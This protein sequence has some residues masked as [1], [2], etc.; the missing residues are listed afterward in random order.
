MN[1]QCYLA[2]SNHYGDR[3]AKRTQVPLMNHINEGLEILRFMGSDFS[4]MEAY[5][6]HPLVQDKTD[7]KVAIDHNTLD[8]YDIKSS[9]ILIAMEYRQVANYYL[10]SDVCDNAKNATPSYFDVVNDMLIADKIQNYKDFM[11]HH[12]ESH[13]N[14]LRL[15][16]YFHQWFQALDLDKQYVDEMVEIIS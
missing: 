15:Y 1:S 7:L 8:Q 2:I 6:L 11:K 12:F 16:T 3:V 13:P 10:S 5:C 9:L 14:Y 4:A